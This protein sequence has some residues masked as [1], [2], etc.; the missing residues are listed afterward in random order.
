MKNRWSIWPVRAQRQSV[1]VRTCSREHHDV[2]SHW[3]LL[4]LIVRTVL[5][6]TEVAHFL[7]VLQ[8]AKL[9]RL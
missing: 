6:T 7:N 9:E 3:L 8:S 2:R 4:K 1:R 5:S